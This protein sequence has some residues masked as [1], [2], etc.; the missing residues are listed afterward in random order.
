M[1]VKSNSSQKPLLSNFAFEITV[2]DPWDFVTDFGSGPFPVEALALSDDH[3]SLVVRLTS[4]I[5][6][7]SVRL[8]FFVLQWR[9]VGT[10][11]DIVPPAE[12]SCN[13]IHLPNESINLGKPFDSTRGGLML[14]GSLR[15]EPLIQPYE[16]EIIGRWE[17]VDGAVVGDATCNRIQQLTS[18]YLQ[19]LSSSEDGWTMLYRDPIDGRHWELTYPHNDWHGGG[20]PSLIQVNPQ[21]NSSHHSG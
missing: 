5:Q 7:G 6:M 17:E 19:L 3:R 21:Y 18:D 16:T 13:L 1:S 15:F 10:R 8:E 2:S 11:I 9:H 12:L 4:P 14:I 20:P